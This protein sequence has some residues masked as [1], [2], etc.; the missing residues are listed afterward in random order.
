MSIGYTPIKMDYREERIDG[1]KVLVRNLREVRLWD[2]SDVVWGANDLTTA[3]K[4]VVTYKET[5]KVS[6]LEA[7]WER[8][9][10][11][12]FTDGVFE[13]LSTAERRRIMDHFAWSET[14]P[15]ER[16]DQLKLPHHRPSRNGVGPVVWNGV[17]AAMAALMG[18]R[19]GADIQ[20]DEVE[21]V[22]RHLSRHYEEFGKEPPQLKSVWACYWLTQVD[23]A[24]YA[25]K[26]D[27]IKDVLGLLRAEPRDP[28]DW[29]L[30]QRLM[31]RLKILE[32]EI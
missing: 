29:A 5:G 14:I 26:A 9:N 3:V 15:P 12:D 18:A 6:D 13:D 8:P 28:S 27:L 30:T 2:I 21:G 7:A 32:R 17:R 11:S 1:E 24:H 22:Y 25:E 20:A 10:L 19:G 31:M 4:A 16:Y 23:L